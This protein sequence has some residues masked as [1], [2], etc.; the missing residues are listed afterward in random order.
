LHEQLVV[1][2]D[3]DA[4]GTAQSEPVDGVLSQP[5]P[6][7]PATIGRFD[8]PLPH[9]GPAHEARQGAPAGQVV[10]DM[11]IA[12]E[13][14]PE[15]SG[16]PSREVPDLPSDGEAVDRRRTGR[17]HAVEGAGE[18]VAVAAVGVAE[19]GAVQ[20]V[21]DVRPGIGDALGR[22]GGQVPVGVLSADAPSVQPAVQA[23]ARSWPASILWGQQT[24][25]EI[26]AALW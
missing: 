12:D 21:G 17:T 26:S 18:Q 7:A 4:F 13:L 11:D 3:E 10:A 24:S 5:C 8:E 19:P 9:L 16:E 23:R 20:N 6:D 14:V 22:G 2:W 25:Q 15:D 1:C